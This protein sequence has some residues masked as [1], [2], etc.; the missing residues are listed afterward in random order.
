MK[1]YIGAD[2]RGYR[3]KEDLIDWLKGLDIEVEDL[4]ANKLDPDDDYVDYAKMVSEAVA[5]GLI[6]T[7]TPTRGIVICGSGVGVDIV[8]NK[9]EGIRC[10]LGINSEQVKAARN[11]DDINILALAADYIK[12]NKAKDMVKLFLET[13]FSGK[14]KHKRRIDKIP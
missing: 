1:I 11:D 5:A 12:P 8:A 4:G 9:T 3:L 13:E 10:G 2:H 6:D 7:T 14:E